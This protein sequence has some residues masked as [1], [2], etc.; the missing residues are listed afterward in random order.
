MGQENKKKYGLEKSCNNRF[1]KATEIAS[2][3][4]NKMAEGELSTKKR[5]VPPILKGSLAHG[6]WVAIFEVH[7]GM[8]EQ[9]VEILDQLMQSMENDAEDLNSQD[10]LDWELGERGHWRVI[11]RMMDAARAALAQAREAARGI[12]PVSKLQDRKGLDLKGRSL[13][14][15]E[16]QLQAKAESLG[17]DAKDKGDFGRS[18]SS[19]IDL[20]NVDSNKDRDHQEEEVCAEPIFQQDEL[21]ETPSLFKGSKKAKSGLACNGEIS[22]RQR[23]SH[24]PTAF[25]TDVLKGNRIH[26]KSETNRARSEEKTN[27]KV[28]GIS[29]VD[30]ST[31]ELSTA[32]IVEKDID[33]TKLQVMLEEEIAAGEKAVQEAR[34]ARFEKILGNNTGY[35]DSTL[36]KRR[37][38]SSD[39]DGQNSD[40]VEIRMAEKKRRKEKKEIKKRKLH[41]SEV[42]KDLRNVKKKKV[43]K[44]GEMKL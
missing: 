29:S 10:R 3:S 14:G 12:L 5:A 8:L 40:G 16:A 21:V 28:E 13:E 31:T 30:N 32:A 25:M 22:L 23:G 33:F 17:Y 24:E 44:S 2:R 19:V 43:R 27:S 1:I 39:F 26:K 9:H 42:D 15:L 35:K 36:K 41:E 37:R 18:S 20:S 34:K 11:C 38:R 4:Q 7:L 6:K